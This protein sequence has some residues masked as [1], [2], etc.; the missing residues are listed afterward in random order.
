[1]NRIDRLTAILIQLQTKRWITSTEIAARYEISQRTVYRDIRALEEAGVPIGSEAGKGYFLV[2]GYRLP[3]VMFTR[4]EAGALLIAEKLVNKLTD[5]SVKKNFDSAID[6]IKAVLPLNDKD[7][8]DNLNS[9]VEVFHQLAAEDT[10]YPNTF[11]TSI[12][13]ALADNKYLIIDY[14]A[15]HSQEK[16]CGRIID[17]LGL[18][19]YG[20]SWHLIG[21]CTLRKDMRDFR[22][23]RIMHLEVS[24]E[25]GREKKPGELKKYFER[26]WQ[27]TDLYEVRIWF[28]KTLAHSIQASKYY[29][30]YIDEYDEKGG[31]VMSFAV[32][33]YSYIANWL[34]SF[35][36]EIQIMYPADL[37][38]YMVGIV[39]KLKNIYVPGN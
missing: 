34:L 2:D 16:T 27:I 25:Y 26:F 28:E 19:F 13:R 17:P 30:G 23:D 35:G 36:S 37:R 8:I 22:L 31:V 20:N 12:Q 38:E 6:K 24:D 29:F 18:V 11:L 14:H 10:N 5:R 21:Y 15:I 9:R 39:S 1:M 33:E 3:P 4:E 32:T 7:V